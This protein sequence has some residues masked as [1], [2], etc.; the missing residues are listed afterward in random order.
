M[1]PETRILIA[2]HRGLVGSAIWRHLTAQG[3]HNLI[4][5]TST[6]LD[7]CDARAAAD[8]C[9][10]TRPD[11]VIGAA[12]AVGGIAANAGRPAEFLSDNLRI[13]VN[14]L[15]SAVASRVQ[16]FLTAIRRQH[17]LP[18]ICWMPTNL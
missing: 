10:D 9:A 5:R 2:G 14:L 6:E 18:N 11:V 13:Q 4:G 17:G 8:F 3:F 15:D 7:L 16:R 12:A 1:S